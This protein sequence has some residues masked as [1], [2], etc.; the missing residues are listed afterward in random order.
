MHVSILDQYTPRVQFVSEE[1]LLNNVTVTLEW[2]QLKEA[3][4]DI[5][6]VPPLP[7]SF[8][9]NVSRLLTLSYNTEYNL[10]VVAIT[11][12]GNATSFIRLH[13]GQVYYKH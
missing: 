13:Y 9:G 5:T 8:I 7:I 11:P 1:R 10:S 2:T 6:V 4:Y 3:M 12:C